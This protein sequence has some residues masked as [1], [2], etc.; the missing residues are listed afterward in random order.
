MALHLYG[1]LVAFVQRRRSHEELRA[2]V[3]QLQTDVESIK[4]D[5]R[6]QGRKLRDV[7][8]KIEM[9]NR[10]AGSLVGIASA[11]SRT[12]GSVLGIK[13]G[14]LIAVPIVIAAI[15]GFLAEVLFWQTGAWTVQKSWMLNMNEVKLLLPNAIKFNV[16]FWLS[17]RLVFQPDHSWMAF[18]D[19]SLTHYL[20]W[21]GS[22]RHSFAKTHGWSMEDDQWIRKEN[23]FHSKKIIMFH[24]LQISHEKI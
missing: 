9:T 17:A 6:A 21:H 11:I 5:L 8:E 14:S 15:F 12:V 3:N 16:V 7:V 4:E 13:S 1:L 19:W 20:P 10:A 2:D 18:P 24:K 22:L 23:Q